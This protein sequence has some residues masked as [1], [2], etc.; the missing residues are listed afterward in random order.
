MD[1]EF[2]SLGKSGRTPT[3]LPHDEKWPWVITIR[4]RCGADCGQVG[5]GA[6]TRNVRVDETLRFRA[7]GPHLIGILKAT[8]ME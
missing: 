3:L 8:V 5:I 4:D 7:D 2:L 1:S 6:E